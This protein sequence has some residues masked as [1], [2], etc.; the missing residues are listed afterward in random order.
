FLGF[1]RFDFRHWRYRRQAERLRHPVQHLAAVGIRSLAPA[2]DQV[3][4]ADLP[5][6]GRQRFA[7]AGGV[8]VEQRRIV[9]QDGVV[10]AHRDGALERLTTAVVAQAQR[11]D[12]AAE[13]LL[14][15]QRL[16]ERIGVVAVH[17]RRYTERRNYAL[18]ARI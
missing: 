9:D 7:G 18:A 15:P 14:Q 8:G 10:G 6:R 1:S 16:L 3:E 17:H 12:L 11:S 13:F 2:Q 5:D 4:G